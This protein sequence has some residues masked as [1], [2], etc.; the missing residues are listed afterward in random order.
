MP[1]P[2]TATK[3]RARA[4]LRRLSRLYPDARCELDYAGPFQL[5]CATILSAQCTDKS[6]NLA[7]PGLFARYPDAASLARARPEAVEALIRRIGLFRNKARNLIGA[8]KALVDRHAGEV[9]RDMDSLKALPGVG[10]KT[11]NVVLFNGF[12]LPGLAVDTHVLRVGKRLGLFES[13]DPVQVES[14]L[15]ALVPPAQWGM[16][17]H[18]LIWHGRRVC[19]ARSPQCGACGLASLCPSRGAEGIR[20]SKP[21]FH[22][23]KLP[24]RRL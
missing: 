23:T 7:T 24:A 3:A 17:S 11:A 10:R 6:V 18:W 1:S 5:L 13:Q 20:A 21:K 22:T 8:A 4:I 16:A 15:G 12:G 2:S 9:P 19:H 14:Q